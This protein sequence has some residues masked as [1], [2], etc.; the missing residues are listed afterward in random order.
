[1]IFYFHLKNGKFRKQ[2]NKK[3]SM[4]TLFAYQFDIKK[5]S[6][7]EQFRVFIEIIKKRTLYCVEIGDQK[8]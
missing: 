4:F 1:M 3:S 7:T 2:K 5:N 6:K 8:S